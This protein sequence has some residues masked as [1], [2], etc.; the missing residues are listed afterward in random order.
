MKLLNKWTLVGFTI[1]LL[2]VFWLA[3]AGSMITSLTQTAQTGDKITA[4]WVNAVNTKLSTVNTQSW[5]TIMKKKVFASLW[6]GPEVARDEWNNLVNETMAGNIYI[7]SCLIKNGFTIEGA[8]NNPNPQSNIYQYCWW[9]ICSWK[10]YQF[11]TLFMSHCWEWSPNC[12]KWEWHLTCM[13]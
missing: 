11:P 8:R 9:H 6:E 1:W 12:W 10:G 5:E 3:Y 13:W 4:T 7:D 2:F